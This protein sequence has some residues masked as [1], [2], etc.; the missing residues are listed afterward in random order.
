[1][2][3]NAA[4]PGMVPTLT[5]THAV[6]IDPKN[7]HYGWVF[8]NHPSGTWVSSRKATEAEFKAAQHQAM[9][10]SIGAHEFAGRPAPTAEDESR[11]SAAL[12]KIFSPGTPGAK[13][14]AEG[15]HDPH[16]ER[17]DCER[18][19]LCM[20]DLTDDE[21]ANGVHLHGNEPLDIDKVMSQTPG[22]HPSIA[23]L[24]AAKDRIRWLSRALEQALAGK[25]AQ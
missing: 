24:T 20:G 9:A 1:M 8:E 6:M 23:W 12:D 13:W 2:N 5:G 11:L 19:N 3:N 16:G 18:A 17:Y 7:G 21:L 14:R 22:Y 15:S 25:G 10:L 4:I